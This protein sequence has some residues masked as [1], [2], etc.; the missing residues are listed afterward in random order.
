[1][2]ALLRVTP[3][4]GELAL[5]HQIRDVH[6]HGILFALESFTVTYKP[7]M[8][9]KGKGSLVQVA[10]VSSNPAAHRLFLVPF[11]PHTPHFPAYDPISMQSRPLFT[12]FTPKQPP[13]Q[14]MGDYCD[15]GAA[16]SL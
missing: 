16:L 5:V 15:L 6:L 11:P 10:V 13:N 9:N 14:L 7:C 12:A 3:W 4:G 8:F 1:M 2:W